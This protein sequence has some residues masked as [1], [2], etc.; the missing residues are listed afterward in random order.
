MSDIFIESASESPNF[1]IGK[2]DFSTP[3][4]SP[5]TFDTSKFFNS[6]RNQPSSNGGF[7]KSKGFGKTRKNNFQSASEDKKNV[8]EDIFNI[9][10]NKPIPTT[11][12]KPK[13]VVGEKRLPFT[14]VRVS[15]SVSQIRPNN[16]DNGIEFTDKVSSSE[17]D[18]TND[19]EELKKEDASSRPLFSFPTRGTPLT[20]TPDDEESSTQSKF[21]VDKKKPEKNKFSGNS[22]SR[23]PFL[24]PIAKF[25]DIRIPSL[26][27]KI[28]DNIKKPRPFDFNRGS[29]NGRPLPPGLAFRT[30][31]TEANTNPS[32][33][34]ET[35][36]ES[37]ST[38]IPT[39]STSTRKTFVNIFNRFSFA[40]QEEETTTTTESVNSFKSLL[41]LIPKDEGTKE[42]TSARS[43]LDLIPVISNDANVNSLDFEDDRIEN[44]IDSS[45]VSEGETNTLR[46]SLDIIPIKSTTDRNSL[47]KVEVTKESDTEDDEKNLLEGSGK[48][49]DLEIIPIPPRPSPS[50]PTTT[51]GTTESVT[52]LAAEA[53]TKK[54][55]RKISRLQ[56]IVQSRRTTTSSPSKKPTKPFSRKKLFDTF[57]TGNRPTISIRFRNRPNVTQVSEIEPIT[58]FTTSKEKQENEIDPTVSISSSDTTTFELDTTPTSGSE[59]DVET[60]ELSTTISKENNFV[61]PTIGGG[62]SKSRFRPSK[63][64]ELF[65]KRGPSGG[66]RR[67]PFLRPRNRGTTPTASNDINDEVESESETTLGTTPDG[68]TTVAPTGPR[69]RPTFRRLPTRPPVPKNT[70]SPLLKSILDRARQRGIN[71]RTTRAPIRVVNKV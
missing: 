37:Q 35:T 33:T 45:N 1:E 61:R 8:L 70:K 39:T 16:N 64:S 12:S 51:E 27:K 65:P 66:N 71:R 36:F 63:L 69:R 28:T 29:G 60:T 32:T 17:K 24:K 10:D 68:E 19:D 47:D 11:T 67:R 9:L 13:V 31:T 6:N 34:E 42:T 43:L 40:T 55:T 44:E 48:T 15:S 50:N 22:G 7:S 56:Q 14:V 2:D 41:E 52:E 20:T 26:D 62:R 57:R 46:A 5:R 30:T 54:T 53:T 25:P 58:D 23:Q 3:P 18:I 21:V 38:E 49:R 4:E 59:D